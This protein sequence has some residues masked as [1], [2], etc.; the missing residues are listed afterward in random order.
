[1]SIILININTKV[2]TRI[3]CNGNISALQADLVGSSPIIRSI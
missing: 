1:M 3:W 2:N